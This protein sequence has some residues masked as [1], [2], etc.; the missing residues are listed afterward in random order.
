MEVFSLL[1]L[2]A[3][4]YLGIHLSDWVS[5]F[6]REKMDMHS[7]F[8]PVTSFIII[9]IVVMIGLYFLGRA[10]TKS[11]SNGGAD[12]WN[13]IGGAFFSL[14]KTL[15]FLSVLFILF[16][17]L[18]SR[19]GILPQQ[20][21]QKSYFYEPIYEFSLFVLPAMEESSFYQKLREEN[22]AP[23]MVNNTHQEIRGKK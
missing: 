5:E 13:Q 12:R 6:L 20:Q 7:P 3:G 19:M 9:L 11:V 22:L 10:I 2:F 15:L 1:S 16:N 23:V 4:V 14:T 18:D 21:K 17:I 8:L